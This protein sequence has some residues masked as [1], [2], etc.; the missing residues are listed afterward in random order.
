MAVSVECNETKLVCISL[1]LSVSLLYILIVL[2][3]TLPDVLCLLCF[4]VFVFFVQCRLGI[5]IIYYKL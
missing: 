5:I 4:A 3:V 1:C 2:S